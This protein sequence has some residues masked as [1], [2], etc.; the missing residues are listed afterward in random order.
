MVKEFRIGSIY[1]IASG[2]G[3]LSGKIV[4]IVKSS[5]IKTDHR[6]VPTNVMGAYRQIDWKAEV[7]CCVLESQ[8]YITMYKNRLIRIRHNK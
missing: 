7:A 3:C 6:G 1:R 2:S 8:E 5:D 4:T